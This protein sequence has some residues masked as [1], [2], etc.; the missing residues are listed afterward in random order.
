MRHHIFSGLAI[1]LLGM[2]MANG[3]TAQTFP[4]PTIACN[5]QRQDTSTIV[6]SGS[7]WRYIYYCS[8]GDWYLE[9]LQR[10]IAGRWVSI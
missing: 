3:A 2:S 10:Y 7:S 1:A 6:Y 9:D 5:E 8:Y 4:T